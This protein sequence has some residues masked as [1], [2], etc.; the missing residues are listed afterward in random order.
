MTEQHH[1]LS[2]NSEFSSKNSYQQELNQ[3]INEF[4][5]EKVAKTIN[6][7]KNSVV[8]YE[9]DVVPKS[10]TSSIMDTG[11]SFSSVYALKEAGILKM[12]TSVDV[13][14]KKTVS[15][16]WCSVL[17]D[18]FKADNCGLR[19]DIVDNSQPVVDQVNQR[20]Q[21]SKIAT[22]IREIQ[23][24]TT[25][26]EIRFDCLSQ[27]E[28]R[29]LEDPLLSAVVLEKL[30]FI[31]PSGLGLKGIF[32]DPEGVASKIIHD[33]VDNKS[34]V[35]KSLE[36]GV[37]I[38]LERQGDKDAWKVSASMDGNDIKKE[39]ADQAPNSVCD[40]FVDRETGIE[41]LNVMQDAGLKFSPSFE[42]F[43]I[44]GSSPDFIKRY[45]GAYTQISRSLA[46]AIYF[47]EPLR[48]SEIFCNGDDSSLSLESL[49]KFSQLKSRCS[50]VLMLQ[51][52]VSQIIEKSQSNG[53]NAK[54]QIRIKEG[55]CFDVVSYYLQAKKLG[56]LEK[57]TILGNNFLHK[58]HGKE[59]LI[60]LSEFEYQ[61][62]T[63]PKG[64]LFV[65]TSENN[66]AFL[67]FTP[68]AFD[69]R[70]DMVS[71]FG[72]EVIKAEDNEGIKIDATNVIPEPQSTILSQ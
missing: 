29:L 7:M 46:K 61:G 24:A 15:L 9:T 28:F 40:H 66:L 71:A 65:Y 34:S 48:M 17:I 21:N 5:D 16:P 3:K 68:F 11:T 31:Y 36:N 60:N 56:K 13:S 1:D 18:R 62:I 33:L 30:G 53:H 55:A 45:G 12:I 69:T 57:I 67:R 35:T 2:N 4:I 42:E 23:P 54:E 72:T 22:S 52:V 70:D 14:A 39:V 37:T 50:P 10:S 27:T 20:I 6:R 63:L 19:F 44:T 32:N 26:G 38:T 49:R 64:C 58:H 25:N 59:T 41:L 51:N 43:I 8:G 47:N